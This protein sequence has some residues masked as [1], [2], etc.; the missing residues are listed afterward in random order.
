MEEI[1][2]RFKILFYKLVIE[3]LN[4]QVV[5]DDRIESLPLEKYELNQDNIFQIQN[6]EVIYNAGLEVEKRLKIRC[7]DVSSTWNDFGYYP[8]NHLNQI[9]EIINEISTFREDIGFIERIKRLS[10]VEPTTNFDAIIVKPKVFKV[11]IEKENKKKIAIMM[12]FRD[13]FIIINSAIREIADH[14]KC[15]CFRVDDFWQDETIIQDIFSLIYTSHIIIVDFT[16][17]NTNVFYETGISHTLGK[18][19]IPIS[20]NIDDVPFDLKHYRILLYE[21]T[22]QGLVKFKQSL[23]Q[24]INA[25]INS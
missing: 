23:K 14:L 17:K 2:I 19:V 16:G 1:P 4:F 9:S 24:R 18:H 12:P 15:K 11:P 8:H 5:P 20:Q 6:I 25:I 13:E 10:Q 21:N 3:I 7:S 22:P